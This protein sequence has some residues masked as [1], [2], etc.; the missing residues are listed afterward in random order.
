ML[1]GT[2]IKNSQ[3]IVNIF[4]KYFLY[5]AKNINSTNAKQ[6][7]Y[8]SDDTTPIDYLLQF[9][10]NPFPSMKLKSLSTKDVDKIIK[11]LK[12]KN[13][14]GYDGISTKLL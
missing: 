11:S 8:N 2:S 10:K 5:L 9:F 12:P 4:N 1:G 14:A 6:S 3:E 7:N 13:S